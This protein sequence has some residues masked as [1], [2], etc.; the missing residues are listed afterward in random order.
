[1]ARTLTDF[2]VLKETNLKEAMQAIT[3]NHKGLVFVADKGKIIGLL[4]DG[5]VRRA[6]IN[7]T[8]FLAPVSGIM[9]INFHHSTNSSEQH[10]LSLM[11][12]HKINA[13]PILNERNELVDVMFFDEMVLK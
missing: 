6:L 4:T 5:D 1:M 9:N 11:K 12:Q 8:H 2:I 13:V 7:G 10:V 3:A